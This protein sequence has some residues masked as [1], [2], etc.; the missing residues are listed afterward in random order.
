MRVHNAQKIL[1]TVSEE[2][3]P[4]GQ[5]VWCLG[6]LFCYRKQVEC[7]KC[8]F[9]GEEPFRPRIISWLTLSPERQRFIFSWKSQCRKARV[10]FGFVFVF[11]KASF[12]ATS[13][14]VKKKLKLRKVRHSSRWAS[15]RVNLL[16]VRIQERCLSHSSRIVRHNL[17]C[18]PFRT[19]LLH[20]L[21]SETTCPLPYRKGP[22]L[23]ASFYSKSGTVGHP[24]L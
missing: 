24:I 6:G 1:H 8:S 7:A 13:L 23:F 17:Y 10:F 12:I 19:H 16:H 4:L 9:P 21:P 22:S 20:S 15:D 2:S 14:Q 18:P 5:W 11:W 3:R